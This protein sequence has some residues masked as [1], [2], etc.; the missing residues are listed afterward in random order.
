MSWA[1]LSDDI[2]E[3]LAPH[4]R[5]CQLKSLH[6]VHRRFNALVKA[7]VTHLT[8][9]HLSLEIPRAFPNVVHLDL[10]RCWNEV[11]DVR[12][13]ALTKIY[14][15]DASGKLKSLNLSKCHGVT[16]KGIAAVSQNLSRLEVLNLDGCRSSVPASYVGYT[17]VSGETL[18]GL[19]RLKKLHLRWNPVTD[20]SFQTVTKL[21]E[22]THLDL[23]LCGLCDAWMVI[24]RRLGECHGMSEASLLSLTCFRKMRVLNL[25][26][27]MVSQEAVWAL[28]ELPVL[29]SLSLRNCSEI[30]DACLMLLPR[31]QQ[32][33]E[34]NLA[35]LNNI[36]DEGVCH[37]IL[38]QK[39]HVLDLTY[40]TRLDGSWIHGCTPE[41]V[42]WQLTQL[43]LTDCCNWVTD[44]VLHDISLKMPSLEILIL[45]NCVRISKAGL[46]SLRR[47]P[48]ENLDLSLCY[49]TCL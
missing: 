16:N 27:T 33:M 23:G 28:A 26:R 47:C 2:F 18:H 22:L 14:A 32:L 34:L 6:L 12:L 5:R 24:F 41:D 46:S 37:L 30:N 43:K 7:Q 19:I 49:G 40:C 20:T 36:T 15:R 9:R 21:T 35:K 48:L 29:S 42:Q 13:I 4:L 10:S 45:R 3:R 25:D 1:D 8:P 31:L 11:N 39:L 38:M 17:G 44:D